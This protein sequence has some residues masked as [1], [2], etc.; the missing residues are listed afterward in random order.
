MRH[1]LRLLL[2]FLL[3]TG[4]AAKPERPAK[5]V[6]AGAMA[7]V[8]S[9]LDIT[10]DQ[11]LES[12]NAAIE[13]S[14]RYYG[15]AGA[16]ERYCFQEACYS[17]PD[18][19]NGL[20][21]LQNIVRSDAPWSEKAKE[22]Q[23]SFVLYES[24]GGDGQ[25]TVLVTGYYEPIL[26]GSLI[27]TDRFRYPLYRMPDETVTVRLNRFNSEFGNEILVGRLK[28]KEVV[29]HYSRKE[30]DTD[31]VLAGRG[32]ELAWV[33]DPVELF[34][35]HIQGSGRI[36][37]PDGKIVRVNYAQK[38]GKPFRGLTTYMVK[39][40]F[41]TEAQKGYE[42]MKA[43]LQANPDV[44]DEI[45]NYNE[46]YIFFRIVEEGPIGSLGLP[47]I[48][49]RSIATDP[50]VFPK[51]AAGLLVSRKPVFDK[52]GKVESWTPYMRIVFSHDAG[53]AIKGPGRV[54]LFCG[55]GADAERVA[56]SLKEKGRLYFLA[57]RRQ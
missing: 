9:L 53:G 6:T 29:P 10:D 8:V 16:R 18:M 54:D 21:V 19:I 23:K 55:T 7:P 31:Q 42:H 24:A 12:L 34:I 52:E 5:P 41:L 37:L 3:L 4:C 22:I 57:P 1:L 27:K 50:A 26:N 25:G 44:R 46:S 17:G 33:D 30:I 14:L 28:G 35:L 43:Y 20:Q 56:G 13:T 2:V 11:D 38:N 51:G 32:L 45:M 40:G 47:I 36:R 39:K 15:R 48:G 49:A